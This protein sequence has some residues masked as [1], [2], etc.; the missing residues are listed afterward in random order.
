MPEK[1][2][3]RKDIIEL[4]SKLKD[5][6][7]EYPKKLADAK[8][9]SFMKQ[10]LDL[11]GSGSSEGNEGGQ[12]GSNRGAKG[13]SGDF[14]KP[15]GS[16]QTSGLSVSS[17]LG[18]ANSGKA[19]GLGLGISMKSVI[20]FGT[21]IA[22][23]TAAYLFREQISEF[24]TEND[25]VRVEETVEPLFASSSAGQ[26]AD[27]PSD[28]TTPDTGTSSPGLAESDSSFGSE[29]D[30]SVDTDKDRDTPNHESGVEP[31]E[32]ASPPIL[33]QPPATP[34]PKPPDQSIIGRLRYLVCILRYGASSCK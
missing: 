29:G 34:T 11:S 16:S 10:I 20:S 12:G 2:L 5:E 23:L 26:T 33:N 32:T 7:P 19:A 17:G 25:I 13:E 8:K 15:G 31:V 27:I 4:L 24:L 30:K 3:D 28:R 6:T 9:D 18:A 1:P 14:G 22:L 21:V